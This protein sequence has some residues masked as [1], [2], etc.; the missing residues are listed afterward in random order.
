M[1]CNHLFRSSDRPSN[2][3]ILLVATALITYYTALTSAL[4]GDLRALC[5]AAKDL[6]SSGK[7]QEGILVADPTPKDLAESTLTYATA[8]RRYV[9]EL[10]SVMPIIIAI[11]LKRRPEDMEVAEFRL[12]FEEFGEDDEKRVDNATI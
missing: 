6:V 7:A 8:K 11:G 5:S 12:V 4:A 10:R 2:N 9:A 1:S 3:G